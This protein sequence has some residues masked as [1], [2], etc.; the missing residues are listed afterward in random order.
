MSVDTALANLTSKL[1]ALP[2][3]KSAPTLI[4]E[5]PGVFPFGIAYERSGVLVARAAGEA[6]DLATLFVEIHVARSL[7]GQA[8]QLA[9]TFRD[10]FL[11]ALIADP[12][13]GGSVSTM[14]DVRR[15]FGVLEWAGVQTIG[16][17][18]EIDVK[19]PMYVV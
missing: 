5:D 19:I 1:A 10:P 16:Y 8:I 12:T 7:L 2:G 18:F 6:N 4:P 13:L 17:R 3:M 14:N 9:S 11:L 15:T